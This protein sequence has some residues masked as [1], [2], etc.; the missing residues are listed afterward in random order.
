MKINKKII[1]C[2][3]FLSG[4]FLARN[5]VTA[6][7]VI[8]PETD[9]SKIKELDVTREDEETGKSIFT[10]HILPGKTQKLDKIEYEI[11][12]H[13]DFPFEDSRGRKYHKIHEPAVFKYS[14]KQEKMVEDLDHYVNF[15][16]PV[17]REQLELIY[18][19]LA[20]H[21]QHPITIPRITIKAYNDDKIVWQHTVEINRSYTWDDKKQDLVLKP[22]SVKK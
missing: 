10:I 5:A 4:L 3:C 2:F 13:Q 21:P 11:D 8:V 6:D 20:F 9:L 16:V 17:G 7:A 19:T 12:Y 18:G 15:R 22:L 1:L 14:L